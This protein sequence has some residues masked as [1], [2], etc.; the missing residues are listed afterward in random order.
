MSRHRV[1][2]KKGDNGYRV[3]IKTK[4]GKIICSLFM[5]LGGKSDNEEQQEALNQASELVKAFGEAIR[6]R[7][8]GQD[9]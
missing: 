7:L 9:E 1:T 5:N 3:A 8:S 4:E 2:V 6:E